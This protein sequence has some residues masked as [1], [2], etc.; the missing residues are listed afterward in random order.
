[1]AII[2]KTD[3]YYHVSKIY[4]HL[5]NFVSYKWWARY[6]IMLIPKEIKKNAAVLEIAAG[7]G[8]LAKYLTKYFSDYIATD[9]SFSMISKAD[10][11]LPRICCDFCY[12]PFKER[13]D[14]IISSFDSI[15]YLTNK[16]QLLKAFKEINSALKKNGIFT[17]DVAL[18]SNSYKHEKTANIS[19]KTSDIVY[20]RKSKYL[21]GSRIHKNIFR[22]KYPDGSIFTEVH[23]QKIYPFHVFYEIADK[24]GFNIL[25]CYKAFTF[26]KGKASSDRV[27][28][29][30]KK[31]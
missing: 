7:N 9:I 28:F 24:S 12:L 2:N 13:F 31:D 6:L 23:R 8:S 29:I 15:N 14:L 30:M 19:G 18:E 11:N 5:M 21:P 17:F 22:I 25:A 26:Q 27:Q 1:M 16:K 20:E 4:S 3:P 10:K